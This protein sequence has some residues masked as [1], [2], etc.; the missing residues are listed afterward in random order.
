MA[1][2]VLHVGLPRAASTFIQKE[3][4][5][6]SPDINYIERRLLKG[7]SINDD[8]NVCFYDKFFFDLDE[9]K[10][11]VISDECICQPKNRND[12]LLSLKEYYDIDRV[13]FINRDFH[14]LMLSFYKYYL[15]RGGNKNF[16]KFYTPRMVSFDYIDYINFLKDNFS[17]VCIVNFDLIYNDFNSFI[18]TLS[19]FLNV[20]LSFV[21][22]IVVNSSKK[23]FNMGLLRFC[24]KFFRNFF[25]DSFYG[26]LPDKL[27]L[28]RRYI[29][30]RK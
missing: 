20:D 23:S 7:Q 26:F 15:L 25:N 30:Y 29:I 16:Y 2:V 9:S 11:N 28:Y 13:L 21:G 19:D 24:N 12:I 18:S 3:I 6:K 10:L 22:N 27:N 5:D 4:L 1:D 14:S 17:N 8:S